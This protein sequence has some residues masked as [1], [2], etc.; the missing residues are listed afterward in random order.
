MNLDTSKP[1]KSV[2]YNGVD[3][4]LA[5][6]PELLWT[7]ASPTSAFAA[8]KMT[9]PAGYDG[10]LIEAI[11]YASYTLKYVEYYSR[12]ESKFFTT[13]ATDLL[14]SIRSVRAINIDGDTIDFGGCYVD[15]G[16][17]NNQYTLPLRI[18]GVKFTLD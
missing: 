12:N 17:V 5:A 7:N 11:G 8:Q 9:M 10:Y 15:T 13:S 2:S 4:P 1:I 14:S 3:V 18:W 16:Y 6:Q